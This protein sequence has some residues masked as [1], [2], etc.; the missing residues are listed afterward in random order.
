MASG[1]HDISTKYLMKPINQLGSMMAMDGKSENFKIMRKKEEFWASCMSAQ[2]A[3][4]T[5]QEQECKNFKDSIKKRMDSIRDTFKD[6]TDDLP[7][8]TKLKI[9]KQVKYGRAEVPDE[10]DSE[11]TTKDLIL[12]ADFF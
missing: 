10:S 6:I 2:E 4:M 5:Y 1:Y 8:E 7:E 12:V 3:I 11:T 9:E